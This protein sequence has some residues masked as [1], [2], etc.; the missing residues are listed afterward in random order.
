MKEQGEQSKCEEKQ[1]V[2]ITIKRDSSRY[3]TGDSGVGLILLRWSSV[4]SG[5]CNRRRRA[6][7][8]SVLI[9]RLKLQIMTSDANRENFVM[10]QIKR[11]SVFRGS[12]T[13]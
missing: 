4:T 12:M 10:I 6:A 11:D 8:R 5:G 9:N 1:F 7:D 3:I 2:M 13:V